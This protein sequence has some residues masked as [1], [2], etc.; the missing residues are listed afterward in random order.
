MG[1][2]NNDSIP[3]EVIDRDIRAIEALL[4]VKHGSVKI[5][6]QKNYSRRSVRRYTI[7]STKYTTLNFE[8]KNHTVKLV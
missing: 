5:T 2:L 4:G 3:A 8:A 7:P 1:R 6:L